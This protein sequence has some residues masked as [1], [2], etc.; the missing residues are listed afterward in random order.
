MMD[1]R[2]EFVFYFQAEV[3]ER[4]ERKKMQELREQERRQDDERERRLEQKQVT[5]SDLS[6]TLFSLCVH[7]EETLTIKLSVVAFNRRRRRSNE[8]KRIRSGGMRRS[9]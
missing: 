5:H 4:E 6:P 1:T 9:T 2:I 8:P 3:E 7:D